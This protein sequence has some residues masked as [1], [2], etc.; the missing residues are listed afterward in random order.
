MIIFLENLADDIENSLLKA[1]TYFSPISDKSPKHK[2]L[3]RRNKKFSQLIESGV[4]FKHSSHFFLADFAKSKVSDFFL[5]KKMYN[6]KEHFIFLFVG[7]MSH[8]QRVGSF[9]GRLKVSCSSHNFKF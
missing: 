6:K 1:F 4:A 2:K 5:K 8:H 9:R 3:K 7:T